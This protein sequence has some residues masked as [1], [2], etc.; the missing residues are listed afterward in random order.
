MLKQSNCDSITKII[1]TKMKSDRIS[2]VELVEIGKS[3]VIGKSPI[4]GKSPMMGKSPIIG[5]SP[6]ND[7]ER[8]NQQLPR[9]GR[10]IDLLPTTPSEDLIDEMNPIEDPIDSSFKMREADNSIIQE[11]YMQS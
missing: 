2:D 4:T 11:A 9:G 1:Q 5:K 7:F 6:D 8:R 3:P 10:P